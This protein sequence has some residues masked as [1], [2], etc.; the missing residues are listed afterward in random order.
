MT[1]PL[2]FLLFVIAAVS[3][4]HAHA[5]GSVVVWGSNSFG[6]TAAPSEAQSGVIAIAAGGSH[7]LAL[8][9][10]GT[11]V[12]WGNPSHGSFILRLSEPITGIA[13]GFKHTVALKKD[14]RRWNAIA[15]EPRQPGHP[16]TRCWQSILSI[17]TRINRES[18]LMIL[19]EQMNF[20]EGPPWP[21]DPV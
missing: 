6:R 2:A 20:R 16:V 1:T 15:H 3:S 10:D 9:E 7:T 14:R 4:A 19:K 17:E 12:A 5:P 11:V 8:K 13:A 21:F 18:L